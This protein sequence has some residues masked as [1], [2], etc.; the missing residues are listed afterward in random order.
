[1][2]V[3]LVN[4]GVNDGGASRAAFRLFRGLG[5][6]NIDVRM[7]VQQYSDNYPGITCSSRSRLGKELAGYRK[8]VDLQPLYTLYPN[9]IKM[10]YSLHWVPDKSAK[11]IN[12]MR[13]DIVNLHWISA[14]FIRIETFGMKVNC[15]LFKTF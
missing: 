3:L 10:P 14:G 11:R 6:N 7:F 2:K 12:Q 13:P 15:P 8:L 5:R 9:R 1:M 4:T